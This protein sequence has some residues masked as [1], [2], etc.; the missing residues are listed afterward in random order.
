MAPH[1]RVLGGFA[2]WGARD[3]F[4]ERP[5]ALHKICRRQYLCERVFPKAISAA[6]QYSRSRASGRSDT[7]MGIANGE[8]DARPETPVRSRSMQCVH[9]ME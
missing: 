9:V 8:A 7:R 4:F 2:G 5:E 6:R 1:A 3:R